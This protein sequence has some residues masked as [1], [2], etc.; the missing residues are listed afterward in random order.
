MLIAGRNLLVE[1][2]VAFSEFSVNDPGFEGE[3]AAARASDR[4]MYRET[5]A[6]LRY[7]VKQG[8]TRVVSEPA[9]AAAQGDGDGRDD[10]SVAT[11]FRCRS[12][13]STTSISSSASPDSQLAL[14]FAGVLAAGNIQRPKLGSTRLDASVDFFAIAVP[15]SDRV[16]DARAANASGERVLTWPLSTGLNLGW[17]YTPFQKVTLQYQFRFDA[18]VHDTTTSEAFERARRAPS[19]TA[20]AAPWEYRRGGYSFVANGAWFRRG[21]LG[22]LGAA[23]ARA[24]RRSR[25]PPPSGR[26]RSTAPVCPGTSTSRSFTRCT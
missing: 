18:Y 16:Y 10:R 22:G 3:R 20:S 12:S 8:D 17:Q 13:A 11:P 4:I 26:T 15:S 5:D 24:A 6:G 9:D 19:P 7:Y 23:R 25:V 14:L 2:S 1:K 21:E